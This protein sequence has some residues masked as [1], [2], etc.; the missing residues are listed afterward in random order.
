MLALPPPPPVHA[1]AIPPVQVMVKKDT[2]LVRG[3]PRDDTIVLRLRAGQPGT[4]EVDAG[5]DGR[6]DAAVS[7]DRFDRIVVLARGGADAVTIDDANG[8]FTDTA[9]TTI[10]G[11]DGND[12]LQGGAGAERLLGGRGDD[13][14]DG[15]RGADEAI[16]GA[17]DDTFRWDPGEGSDVVEGGDGFDT[18][19]FNGANVAEQFDVSANGPR[20]RF[21]RDVG[22][23]TMDLGGVERIDTAALG[24]ADTFHQ[25]D[26]SGTELVQDD[27]DLAGALGGDAGDGAADS[28]SATATAGDDLVSVS[29]GAAGVE[30][31][32]L[33]A[34]LRVAHPDAADALSVDAGAGDDVV[35]AQG[36]TAGALRYTADGGEGDDVLIG[37][38]GADVLLGGPG[39]DLLSGGPGVDTLDGGPGDNVVIQD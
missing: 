3:T 39:D 20:V 16:L 23:I 17:G 19:A 35:L 18:M 36:L 33:P 10:A 5:G 15:G 6:A 21:F 7:R 12:R 26:V 29:G 38:A 37:S 34:V 28:V 25:G 8:T 22:N 14:A 1:P 9:P 11:G 13:F 4:L 30:V 32:G 31:A 24:G 2:L 27:V